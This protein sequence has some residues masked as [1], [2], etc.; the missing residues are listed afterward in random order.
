MAVAT[1]IVAPPLLNVAYA[2]VQPKNA[3]EQFQL[4]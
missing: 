1:T 4:G 2:G 3:E